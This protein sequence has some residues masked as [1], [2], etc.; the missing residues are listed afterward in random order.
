MKNYSRYRFVFPRICKLGC[1]WKPMVN[2]TSPPPQKEHQ[3][4]IEYDAGQ[5]PEMFCTFWRRATFFPLPEIEP[6]IVQFRA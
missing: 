4:P 1:G 5:V 6:Q 3:M 2:L